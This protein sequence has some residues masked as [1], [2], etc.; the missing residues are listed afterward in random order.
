MNKVAE[1][2]LE[3]ANELNKEAEDVAAVQNSMADF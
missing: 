3:E 1:Q 2:A